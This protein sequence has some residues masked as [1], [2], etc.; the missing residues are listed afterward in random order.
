MFAHHLF[1]VGLSLVFLVDP[2]EGS[3]MLLRSVGELLP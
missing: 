1:L 2:D 3:G